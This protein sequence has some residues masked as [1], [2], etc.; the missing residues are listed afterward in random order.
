MELELG[1]AS[2]NLC[3]VMGT[4]Q[5]QTPVKLFRPLPEDVRH[6]WM[7]VGLE[8]SLPSAL[9]TG[10]EGTQQKPVQQPVGAFFQTG[11][12]GGLPFVEDS[13]VLSNA[14]YFFL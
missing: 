11:V 2:P 13:E 14:L 9:S 5:D 6:C 8:L 10:K 1:Q 3:L 4:F 12:P 7:K